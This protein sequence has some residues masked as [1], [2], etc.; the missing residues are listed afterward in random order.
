ME[1]VSSEMNDIEANIFYPELFLK[2]FM[3]GIQLISKKGLK[4]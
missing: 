1:K 2:S 3:S 4:K